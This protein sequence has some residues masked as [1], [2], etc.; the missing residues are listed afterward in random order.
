MVR[1]ITGNEISD[2]CTLKILFYFN[3]QIRVE[4][5]SRL[6]LLAFK[7]VIHNPTRSFERMWTCIL[8]RTFCT[9][10]YPEWW[11]LRHLYAK[12]RHFPAWHAICF[13]FHPETS[14]FTVTVQ[15]I[16]RR[17]FIHITYRHL[18]FFS[19]LD[20][21]G[22][23]LILFC[24]RTIIRKIEVKHFSEEAIWLF[25]N[26]ISRFLLFWCAGKATKC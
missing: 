20:L 13:E 12:S 15:I 23:S 21:N 17:H 22:Y 1:R 19:R 5:G 7:K 3:S 14:P 10:K 24:V 4:H 9:S 25:C 8:K 16:L 26:Y 6:D 2:T 18:M 11:D